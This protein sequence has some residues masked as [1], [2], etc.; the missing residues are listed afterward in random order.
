MSLIDIA[1]FNA[2][3]PN[4]ASFLQDHGWQA[5]GEVKTYN[6]D[7]K[8]ELWR[9]NEI[10]DACYLYLHDSGEVLFYLTDERP[11]RN[12]GRT[13]YGVYKGFFHQSEAKA[14]RAIRRRLAA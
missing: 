4:M 14:L 10:S 11:P 12:L 6:A 3:W 5:T 1:R 2:L 9:H 7:T 13:P 8:A